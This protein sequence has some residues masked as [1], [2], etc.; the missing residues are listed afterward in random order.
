MGLGVVVWSTSLAERPMFSLSAD[1]DLERLADR[2]LLF[3]SHLSHLSVIEQQIYLMGAGGANTYDRLLDWYRELMAE[4]PG[5]R[6]RAYVGVLLGESGDFEA[7]AEW[8]SPKWVDGGSFED[9]R[10]SLQAAYLPPGRSRPDTGR[11]Q[12]WLAE[13]LPGNWFYFQLA[14]R[15]A[16]RAGDDSL[17]SS[18]S[19]Q[20]ERAAESLVLRW[21]AGLLMELLLVVGG[22]LGAGFLIRGRIPV[23]PQLAP[24]WTFEEGLA[25][26]VRGGALTVLLIAGIAAWPGGP[27]FMMKFGFLVLYGPMILLGMWLL[28]QP[29]SGSVKAVFGWSNVLGTFRS[30]F[31]VVLIVL[32][33]GVLGDWGVMV[34]GE[35]L[36]YRVHWTEW[37]VPELVWGDGWDV[38]KRGV[39][40]VIVAPVFEEII[41]RGFVFSTLLVGYGSGAALAGSGILF[42]LAHGYGFLA[43]LSVLWSGILWA[44]AYARTGSLIPGIV[45]HAVNNGIVVYA[46]LAFF[47]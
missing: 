13:E 40:F 10:E 29:G 42:A 36:G 8:V 46:L 19:D 26:L 3:E 33:A 27:V 43:F 34:I 22:V 6:N 44:W 47:R 16:E 9:I 17:S 32:G 35:A 20:M 24:G 11:L 5:A 38:F 45:A 4:H 12:A 1:R 37:F 15:L 7:L 2:I 23:G 31:P 39:E 14:K 25:V 18:L 41:F 28:F 30:T 21:R